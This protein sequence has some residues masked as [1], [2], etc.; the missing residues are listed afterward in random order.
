LRDRCAF[1]WRMEL[2][3][4]RICG[5]PQF[6]TVIEQWTSTIR[7]VD[8]IEMELWMST[9]PIVDIQSSIDIAIADNHNSS[10]GYPQLG[11]NFMR[12]FQ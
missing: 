4:N 7:L 8:I 3:F 5:Y 12:R 10:C 9:I 11:T 1:V 2:A 6:K